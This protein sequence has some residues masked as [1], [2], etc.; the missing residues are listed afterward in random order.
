VYVVNDGLKKG[1]PSAGVPDGAVLV[2]PGV[3]GGEANI[4]LNFRIG[5]VL[6]RFENDP[7][8]LSLGRSI[9]LS[10]LSLTDETGSA[11][12]TII[13]SNNGE[14]GEKQGTGRISAARMYRIYN[15]GNTSD[16]YAKARS[17][18]P[19]SGIWAWTA[20][21]GVSANQ[22]QGATDIAV[23]FPAGE[24]H[25][26]LIRGI[27][28]FALLQFNGENFPGDPQFERIDSSGWTYSAQE[29]TL[30]LK[31]KQRSASERIRIIYTA[32]AAPAVA[33]AP[34]A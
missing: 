26:M 25:Y 5:S 16:Y 20:S 19:G 8:R 28:P 31:V 6:T 2:F 15:M 32:P 33:P 24:T 27:R 23:S 7:T 22:S 10:V 3:A 1:R 17:L 14:F 4:E 13:Q 29:Q 11:P 18:A 21:S 34:E 30:L 9:I 12:Q